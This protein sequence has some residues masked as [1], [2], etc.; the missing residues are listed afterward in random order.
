MFLKV[1]HR[2][3]ESLILKIC[4]CIFKFLSFFLVI[5]GNHNFPG[6][7]AHETAPFYNFDPINAT[8]LILAEDTKIIK[9]PEAYARI[10]GTLINEEKSKVQLIV[11]RLLRMPAITR[12]M[13]HQFGGAHMRNACI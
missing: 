8:V 4:V 9:W 10:L 5:N 3:N 13:K 6:T 7:R 1:N 11:P 12:K 2:F